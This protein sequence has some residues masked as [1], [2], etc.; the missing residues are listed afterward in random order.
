MCKTK[1][2]FFIDSNNRGATNPPGHSAPS[3]SDFTINLDHQLTLPDGCGVIVDSFNLPQNPDD[4]IVVGINNLVYCQLGIV[5]KVLSLGHISTDPADLQT[6]ANELQTE[7]NTAFPLTPALH[8][9][10]P[11]W[12]RVFSNSG[13][14]FD[15]DVT[16]NGTNFEYIYRGDRKLEFTAFDINNTSATLTETRNGTLHDIFEWSQATRTFVAQSS[17]YDSKLPDDPSIYWEGILPTPN[18]T[19]FIDVTLFNNDNLII[20]PTQG[21]AQFK[22]LTDFEAKNAVSPDAI[23]QL[24]TAQKKNLQSANKFLQNLGDSSPVYYPAASFQR[25][26]RNI[27]AIQSIFIRSNLSVDNDENIIKKIPLS[28]TD[29]NQLSYAGEYDISTEGKIVT[30]SMSFRVTDANNNLIN[31]HGDTLSFRLAFIY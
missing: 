22:I 8:N 4:N 24:T 9:V 21:N 26:L 11:Q 28:S 30:K 13:E 20:E 7:L 31:F 6:L 10:P 14:V 15:E 16:F 25:V 1:K 27:P 17:S 29:V 18:I 19:Q 2:V 3:G 5:L 12:Q 23:P